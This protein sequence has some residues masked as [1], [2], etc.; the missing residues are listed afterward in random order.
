MLKGRWAGV[1][2]TV[3]GEMLATALKSTRQWAVVA[4][5]GLAGSPDLPKTVFPFIIRGVSLIGIDS[6][7]CPM[8][9]RRQIWRK[10]ASEWKLD[11]LEALCTEFTL[12]GLDGHID[13]ILAGKQKGRVVVKL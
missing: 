6:Q 12:K 8:A 2:D 7:N 3:G 11:N 13:L 4:C 5:C 10:L 9:Q 1:V